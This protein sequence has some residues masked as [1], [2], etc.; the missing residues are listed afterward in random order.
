[1]RG[2][3]REKERERE[4]REIR[5][6][7]SLSADSFF[8][9]SQTQSGPDQ[10]HNSETS[11]GFPMSVS[12]NQVLGPSSCAL[13]RSWVGSEESGNWT[14]VIIWD[15]SVTATYLSCCAIISV[16]GIFSKCNI[17]N[18][19]KYNFPNK[20]QASGSEMVDHIV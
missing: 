6:M 20:C 11:T 4:K 15:G 10:S 12:G 1:M 5:N 2:R 9:W 13:A 8:H 7:N 3:N 18:V 19:L 16:S 17:C 14:S